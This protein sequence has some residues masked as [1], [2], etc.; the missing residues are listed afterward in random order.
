VL[1]ALL[2]SACYLWYREANPVSSFF[3][4]ATSCCFSMKLVSYFQVNK[5][6]RLKR[7]IS[8]LNASGS[9]KFEDLHAENSR[10]NLQETTTRTSPSS[11]NKSPE[12]RKNATSTA[13]LDTSL[14]KSISCSSCDSSNNANTS[15]LLDEDEEYLVESMEPQIDYPENLTL[16]HLYFFIALPTLCY[17]INFPRSD[18]IRKRFLMRRVAEI[19]SRQ[20]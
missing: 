13:N 18:R 7:S 1:T 10:E 8:R 20:L 6:Y 9:I 4:L 11:N 16:R 14:N 5:F 2:L 15:S 12:S 3:A 17:E 19:V